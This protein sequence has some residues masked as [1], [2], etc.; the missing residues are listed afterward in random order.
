MW[1]HKSPVGGQSIRLTAKGQRGIPA[2]RQNRAENLC[3]VVWPANK[4]SLL[5]SL[6]PVIAPFPT[7]LFAYYLTR[8]IPT[9]QVQVCAR[10]SQYPY[11]NRRHSLFTLSDGADMCGAVRSSRSVLCFLQVSRCTG[12]DCITWCK[13]VRMQTLV[14]ADRLTL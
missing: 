13:N 5:W 8:V 12:P 10:N 1:V 6:C 9:E 14:I 4:V 7:I 3:L 11:A 2:S